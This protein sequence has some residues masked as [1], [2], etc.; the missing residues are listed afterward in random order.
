MK[1]VLVLI[2][3]ILSTIPTASAEVYGTDNRLDLKDIHSKRWKSWAQSVAGIVHSDSLTPE[4]NTLFKLKTVPLKKKISDL[5]ADEPFLEQETGPFCTAF[6]V[7]ENILATAGH[8][9]KNEDRCKKLSFLFDY[10][11]S[12]EGRELSR[13]NADNIF[14]CEKLLYVIAEDEVDF[15]LIKLDHSPMRPH[16]KLRENF[17]ASYFDPLTILGFPLGLP[18]KIATDGHLRNRAGKSLTTT[19]DA[20]YKNSGSPVLGEWSG[21]VEGILLGGDDDFVEKA[22]CKSTK[23]CGPGEC[24][25]TTL[26]KSKVIAQKLKEFS[27]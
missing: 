9:I 18:L 21:V 8:C 5:C 11:L 16:F 10:E 12:Q 13:V 24:D 22:G 3:V 2:L 14:A 6:L 17:W 26:L 7:S 4:G 25:G 27:N 1:C 23:I 20:F 19:V 15:A